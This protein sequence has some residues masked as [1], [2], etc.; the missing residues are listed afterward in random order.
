MYFWS[1]YFPFPTPPRTSPPLSPSN[2]MLF[3]SQHHPHKTQSKQTK[4]KTPN[5]N[6]KV[7]KIRGIC[8]CVGQLLLGMGL[9]L[10][11]DSCAQY[12]SLHW[13]KLI[14]PFSADISSTRRGDLVSTSPSL[15]RAFVWF[16]PVEVLCMRHSLCKCPCPWLVC[17]EDTAS[18]MSPS[19]SDSDKSSLYGGPNMCGTPWRRVEKLSYFFS[20]SQNKP[21]YYLQFNNYRQVRSQIKTD[22]YPSDS[23]YLW[24]LYICTK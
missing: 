18:F 14:F 7:Y 6:T 3:L 15:C 17:L 10:E 21:V 13:R 23:E 8:F 9:G 16:E 11:F 2:F 1:F 20:P 22:L 12:H 5:Q 24:T 4:Q 19:T